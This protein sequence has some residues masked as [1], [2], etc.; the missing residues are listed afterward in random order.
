MSRGSPRVG[1]EYPG[2]YADVRAWFPS[3][4]ACLD[5]LDWLRW[6]DGFCC[7]VCRGRKAWKLPDG[8][9]SCGVCGRRVSATAGTIFHRTR[10]P[11]TIWFAAAWQ[12]TSQKHGIS[13]LGLKRTLGIGSEQTAWAMLHRYRTAMVR[14][15]RER[16]SGIV[17]VDETF[18]GGA[19]A[20]RPRTRRSG[21]GDGRGGCRAGRPCAW[22]L[23]ATG[24]P[25]CRQPDA[26]GVH[27]RPRSAWLDRDHRSARELPAGVWRGLHAS[28]RADRP[29]RPADARATPG[30]APG[31]IAGTALAAGHSPGRRQARAH[32]GIPGRVHVPL[33]PPT[34]ARQR[35]ALLP[36]APTGRASPSSHLSLPRSRPR[37]WAPDP[38]APA[39]SQARPPRQPRRR[40][41]RSPM[42]TYPSP[43]RHQ[44]RRLTALR[45]RTHFPE[46]T[47]Q[48]VADASCDAMARSTGRAA[49]WSAMRAG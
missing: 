32:T 11:L 48:H 42:A 9:W 12:M 1:I 23:P 16:L 27:A 25:R 2:S 45:W 37:R 19:R 13:A 28:A 10:T 31:R 22:P 6:P 49:C 34:L 38:A 20:G 17:E 30:R 26:A 36:P 24:D 8:R 40:A 29:V 33:Q 7:P 15:G 4:V 14:P 47:R 5:Y 18:L 3:D 44:L 21:E 43:H 46:S 35:H 39:A 41:H